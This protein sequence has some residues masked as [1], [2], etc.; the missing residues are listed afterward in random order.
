MKRLADRGASVAH[1]PASNL[2]LGSGLADAR[3]L[4]EAGVNV[5][6][7]SDGSNSS[8]NQNMIEAMRLAAYVS[9]V[10]THDVDEW[11]SSAEALRMA[12]VGGARTMGFGDA[13]GR[14]A[15]GYKADLAFLDLSD[16]AYVPLNDPF[17]QLVY[18]DDGASVVHVMVDGRFVYENRRFVTIDLERTIADV[19][20]A[21]ERLN[22]DT[23]DR[24]EIV[25]ALEPLVARHCLCFSA[26]PYRVGRMCERRG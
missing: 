20:A 4:V 24:R 18:A 15:E 14:V 17:N 22:R 12:T 3:A 26:R 5:G 25:A 21:M 8:D 10:Q 7:G 11:V 6:L 16:L 19:E 9:R 2:R 13:I 23:A 1:N